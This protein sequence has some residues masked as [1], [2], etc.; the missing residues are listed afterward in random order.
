MVV[1]KSL[2]WMVLVAY[3]VL[4][5]PAAIGLAETSAKDVPAGGALAEPRPAPSLAEVA[6]DVVASVNG[7]QLTRDQLAALA[8]GAY[9]RQVQESLISQ[10]VVRQ[11]AR[12]LGVSASHE[13][14]DAYVKMRVEEHLVDM[15]ERMGFKD[16]KAFGE[17]LAESGRSIE[18]IRADALASLAPFTGPELLARKL[19][20]RTIKVKDADVRSE[21]ERR[22]GPKAR[23]LQVVLRTHADAK[24]VAKKL[25]MGADF[26]KLA[27]ERSIDPVS[28]R[29]GGAIPPLP[30]DSVLGKAA[31]KLKPGQVSGV[32]KGTAGFHVIRLQEILPAEDV[33]LA[34]VQDSLREEVIERR[35]DRALAAWLEELVT[36]AKIEHRYRY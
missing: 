35:V 36:K 20:R 24:D 22:H 16:M 26:A 21:F 7:I 2:F 27:R 15:A 13:E 29:A 8:V 28:R 6:P 34:D 33:K 1:R 18:K 31:F 3:G 5:Q 25:S 4:F 19:I 17:R 10:E 9:G 32:I 23:V 11:E 14:V 12:R 30:R